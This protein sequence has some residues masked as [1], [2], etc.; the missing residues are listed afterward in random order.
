M[1]TTFNKTNTAATMAQAEALVN[2]S[3]DD[4]LDL[5][6]FN[7]AHGNRLRNAALAMEQ[8]KKAQRLNCY[9]NRAIVAMMLTTGIA[10]FGSLLTMLAH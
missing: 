1:N 4:S 2:S 9:F 8:Y 10:C 6:A 3:C 5:A 7:E